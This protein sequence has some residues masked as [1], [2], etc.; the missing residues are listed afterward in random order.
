MSAFWTVLN[1]INFLCLLLMMLKKSRK[2]YILHWLQSIRRSSYFSSHFQEKM[3][4]RIGLSIRKR[5][6]S[7]FI[8][9]SKRREEVFPS[10]LLPSVNFKEPQGTITAFQRILMY[11]QRNKHLQPLVKKGQA[12]LLL[13]KSWMIQAD[14]WGPMVNSGT[15]TDWMM[16]LM[17]K[18]FH[19]NTFQW[20]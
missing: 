10:L 8:L 19:C 9:G 1:Q 20:K 3:M 12:C 2:L 4:V 5:N 6:A 18:F 7:P 16:R 15:N 14:R 11:G 13:H 17:L